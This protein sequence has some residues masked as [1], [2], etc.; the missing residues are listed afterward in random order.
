MNQ[1]VLYFFDGKPEAL[2]LYEAFE[3]RVLSKIGSVK[4]RVQK[5]DRFF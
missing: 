1:D 2:P 5:T 4:V 3:K